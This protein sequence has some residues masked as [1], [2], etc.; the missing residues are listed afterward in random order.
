MKKCDLVMKGGITSGIVYPRAVAELAKEFRFVN[1][2]GTSAGAIAAALTA[3]AEHRRQS[4]Q[5][6]AGFDALAT[7][8]KWLGHNDGGRSRLL[9]LFRPSPDAQG[10][11]AIALAWIETPGTKR[12]KSLATLRALGRHFNRYGS[13][14]LFIATVLIAISVATAW[15]LWDRTRIVS[16][17]AL[18]A[19][20]I[21]IAIAAIAFF[22]AA[23]VEMIVTALRVLP[24]NGFGMCSGAN[25][26]TDWLATQIDE[27][28]GTS[29]PLTFGD[30]RKHGINFEMMT[31]NLTHGR[32]Y[33][34]PFD[35]RMFFF[36]P[37]EM[38]ALFPER[39][40]A[41]MIA[42]APED[43]KP[44]TTPSGETLVPF[45]S[46]DDLPVIVATRLSLSFPILLSALPLWSVDYARRD[47]AHHAERCW[48]SDGGITS[49][50]PVHFFDAPVPRWPTFAINLAERTPRYHEDGQRMYVPTSNRGGTNE[51]W[52]PLESLPAFMNA[53]LE[54]MQNWRDNMTAKLI[55]RRDLIAHVLLAPNEGGLNLTMDAPTIESVASRGH[56]AGA[57]FRSNYDKAWPNHRWIR[58][59]AFMGSLEGT[60]G[61]WSDAFDETLFDAPP[62]SYKVSQEE[63]RAMRAAAV[64][65]HA[66]VREN[67]AT[68]PFHRART[69]RPEAMLRPMPRE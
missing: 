43:S 17:G 10:L 46:A 33:R 21:T 14:A 63:R 39:V 32:P 56:E 37:S 58:C 13:I 5:S 8:P 26:L 3:A 2:G 22:I 18:V 1:I 42:C 44:I 30:L 68:R 53:I 16:I 27:V 64:A 28:A 60:L 36:A 51:W 20:V 6:D 23:I 19:I 57:A 35:V 49:N 62:P 15:L 31:T 34:L 50:F 29:E 41:K 45:P 66:H 25:G 4:Q 61:Q 65:L 52:T 12:A 59:L 55:G 48:F 69:P 54:T 24:R 11:F 67:F 9:S 38:R 40:V 7:L 47:V